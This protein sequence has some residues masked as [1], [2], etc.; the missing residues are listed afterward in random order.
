MKSFFRRAGVLL[1]LACP[2]A[3]PAGTRAEG[4]ARMAWWR[5]AGFGL[6]IHYGPVTLTGKELSWSRANSN[7]NCPNKGPT[8]VEVHDNLYKDFDPTNFNARDWTGVAPG[9]WKA[10]VGQADTLT[11]LGA[12]GGT[13]SREALG[14]MPKAVF[15]LDPAEIEGRNFNARTALRFPLGGNQDTRS[16]PSTRAARTG[17]THCRNMTSF[18]IRRRNFTRTIWVR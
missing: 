8:P 14:R 12:A 3:A 1:S 17:S 15:P 5:E 18:A 4:A 13:P 11:L 9:V 2:A 7:T 6:F 10:T 16:F